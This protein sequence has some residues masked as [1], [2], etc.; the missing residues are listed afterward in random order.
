MTEKSRKLWSSLT[1]RLSRLPGNEAAAE[2]GSALAEWVRENRTRIGSDLLARYGL[3][4]LSV[5]SFD[6]FPVDDADLNVAIERTNLSKQEPSSV[7]VIAMLVRDQI[8]NLVAFKTRIECPNCGED[9]LR[10]LIDPGTDDAL[11]LACDFCGWAQDEQGR[12]WNGQPGCRPA[13]TSELRRR[14][15]LS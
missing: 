9:E 14:G 7:E 5:L 11:V 13:K 15:L 10:A 8:W 2:Y 3:D 1:E 4:R 6:E 12:P